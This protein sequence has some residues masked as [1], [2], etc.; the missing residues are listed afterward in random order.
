MMGAWFG[1][2]FGGIVGGR[3]GS[4]LG[5]IIGA[6]I[7]AATTLATVQK[8][9]EERQAA[10]EQGFY[11]AQRNEDRWQAHTASLSYLQPLE[12]SNVTWVT[13]GGTTVLRAGEKATLSFDIY[14]RGKET[15]HQLTPLVTADYKRILLSPAAVID[16]IASGKGIRYRT[17]MVV[18][19]N[20]RSRKVNFNIAFANA[21]GN[22][23]YLVKTFSVNIID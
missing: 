17:Q 7:G 12:V 13:E 11:D 3:T 18:K 5:S 1:S 21:E 4:D 8:E 16:H 9:Q 19:S 6:G 22:E 2:A 23:K 20:A 15:I 14:N 10:Y